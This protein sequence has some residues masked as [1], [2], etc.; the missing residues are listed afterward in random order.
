M[1]TKTLA[2]GRFG[3]LWYFSGSQKSLDFPTHFTND[4]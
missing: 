4:A 1:K 2:Q 3:L